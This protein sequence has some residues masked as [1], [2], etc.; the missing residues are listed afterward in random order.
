MNIEKH[1]DD[2]E[3]TLMRLES[4]YSQSNPVDVLEIR[5]LKKE[6]AR[7]KEMLVEGKGKTK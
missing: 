5:A 4:H 7:L 2:L 1:I 6:I 3:K